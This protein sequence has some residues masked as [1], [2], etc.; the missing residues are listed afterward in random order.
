[1]GKEITDLLHLAFKERAK[2]G[3][4]YSAYSQ[5]VDRPIQQCKGWY[6]LVALV[7]NK[8]L[9]TITVN[10]RSKKKK[11]GYLCTSCF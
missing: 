5:T 6:C 8:L 3:L 11:Y 9:G 2:E 1:M 10:F 7:E 4:Y